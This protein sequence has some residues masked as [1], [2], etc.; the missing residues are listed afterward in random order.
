MP[1]PAATGSDPSDQARIAARELGRRIGS[2][3]HDVLVALSP[4]LSG[5]AS[6]LGADGP[7][8]D[9]TTLPW[10]PRSTASTERAAAWSMP[11][12]GRR[13]LLM[14]GR[15]HLFEGF[16][17]GQVAHPVRTAIACGCRVVVLAGMASSVA[18]GLV[19][20]RLVAVRDHLNLTGRS[21]LAGTRA[22]SALG[23]PFVD[24]TDA[25]SPRLR[26]LA[27]GTDPSLGDGVYAQVL[28]PELGTAAEA[29]MLAALGADMV[30]TSGVVEAVAARQL[31]AEVLGLMVVTGEVPTAGPAEEAAERAAKAATE[32]VPWLA[33]VLRAVL[34]EAG[35]EEAGAER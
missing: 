12:G 24:L 5:V 33:A 23:R 28:G 10:F 30:G 32:A 6:L 7:P 13:V 31:G 11:V 34:E 29:R 22:D 19:P 2:G 26:A 14:S 16:R 4:P 25:W 3:P 27:H 8:L 35:L 20:G 9:L 18:P 17:V 15:P 1:R 21:P